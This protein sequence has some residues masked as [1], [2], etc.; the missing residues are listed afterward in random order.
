M[1]PQKALFSTQSPTYSTGAI[2]PLSM[3]LIA[4]LKGVDEGRIKSGEIIRIRR[5]MSYWR[6]SYL[7]VICLAAFRHR[8]CCV[9]ACAQGRQEERA[10][11]QG[12]SHTI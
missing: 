12:G 6:E 5:L 2:V 7:A 9:L 11:Q 3:E 8:E 1:L 10:H 4:D